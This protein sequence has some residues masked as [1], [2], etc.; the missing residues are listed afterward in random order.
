MPQDPLVRFHLGMAQAKTGN[1]EAARE[2][3]TTAIELAGD[4]DLPQMAEA[5]A[6]LDGL[7]Q[8]AAGGAQPPAAP[9]AETEPVAATAPATQ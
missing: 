6:T 1:T 9:A 5:Q 4:R 8:P 3:L 7:A 2:S